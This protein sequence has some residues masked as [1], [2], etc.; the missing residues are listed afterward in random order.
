MRGGD[1]ERRRL[2]RIPPQ[3]AI[4]AVL[5]TA[6]LASSFM[7][8]LVVPI[9]A[10]LPELLDAMAEGDLLIITADHGCDPTTAWSTD[11]SREYT[12][13]IAKIKGVDAGVP[14]GTRATFG[15]IG[16]TVLHFYGLQDRC[17]RG[18]SFLEEVR[19]A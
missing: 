12:P 19:G 2:T 10:K 11:H 5:A 13:L 16:E 4:V 7:Y 17:G 14:L 8:T 18:A 9:Q 3:G 1:R 15:D 6:G